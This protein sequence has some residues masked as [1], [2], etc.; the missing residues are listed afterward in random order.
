MQVEIVNWEKFNPRKDLKSSSWLRLENTFCTHPDFFDLTNDQKMV[1]I[2]MLCEASRKQAATITINTNM[3]A[4]ILKVESCLVTETIQAFEI[5]GLVTL[6]PRDAHVTRTTRA[7]NTLATGRDARVSR[8]RPTNERTTLLDSLAADD[9][10]N[11]PSEAAA[12]PPSPRELAELW[13]TH[14]SPAQRKVAL[15]TFKG[16]SIRWKHAKA[17][18]AENNDL[19]YWASVIDR[20]AASPF[21]NGENNRGWVAN[22]DFFVRPD[23]HVKTLEDQYGAAPPA[24]GKSFGD[25]FTAEERERYGIP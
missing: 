4:A 25:F 1:W 2:F 21:C 6:R 12:S 24:L 22:F 23:T 10:T 15:K 17:R 5:K 18:L 16:G 8:C 11:V 20:I 7:R 19:T 3:V 13:N 14:S 9:G